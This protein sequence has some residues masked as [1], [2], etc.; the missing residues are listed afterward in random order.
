MSIIIIII[1][2]L[3]AIYVSM[4]AIGEVIIK[5]FNAINPRSS[6]MQSFNHTINNLWCVYHRLEKMMFGNS[7][8]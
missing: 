7:N 8:V 1:I 4:L 6:Q 2:I 5:Y 3:R